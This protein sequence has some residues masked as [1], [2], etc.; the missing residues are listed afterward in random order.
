MRKTL[1]IYIYICYN[2]RVKCSLY[3]F[4]GEVMITQVSGP[5][6]VGVTKDPRRKS[7]SLK[8]DKRA[9]I[10][11][12]AKFIKEGVDSYSPTYLREYERQQKNALWTSVSI[13]LGSA[14]FTI[15]YFTLSA[16]KK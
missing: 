8:F 12:N 14:L 7:Q 11:H 4:L 1:E 5:S 6:T 2:A 15:G 9:R 10:P 13:V 16:L 3:M